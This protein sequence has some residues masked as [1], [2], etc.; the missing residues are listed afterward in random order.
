MGDMGEMYHE[1]RKRDKQRKKKNLVDNSTVVN[2]PG[3][4]KHTDYHY[5]YQLN[6]KRL[7]FWPSRNK[8]QFEGKIVVGDLAGFIRN[9]EKK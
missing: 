4:T 6:G 9:R 2:S 1:M 3:W 5:S 8:W 7:D